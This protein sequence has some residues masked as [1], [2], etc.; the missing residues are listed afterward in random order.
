MTKVHT[1]PPQ[2]L[3]LLHS[4]TLFNGVLSLAPGAASAAARGQGNAYAQ[5]NAQEHSSKAKER[6]TGK[7]VGQAKRVEG[8]KEVDHLGLGE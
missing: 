1:P 6:E 5:G 8:K 7:E 2:P 3:F 4:S